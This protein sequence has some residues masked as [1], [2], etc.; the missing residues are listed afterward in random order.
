MMMMRKKRQLKKMVLLL[1]VIV[2]EFYSLSSALAVV[3]VPREGG[4]EY[5]CG[6]FMFIRSIMCSA[7]NASK[8]TETPNVAQKMLWIRIA[9][10]SAPTTVATS[11]KAMTVVM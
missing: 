11:N 10:K 1:I 9:S 2:F 3:G 8:N 4:F 5:S 6:V 7:I